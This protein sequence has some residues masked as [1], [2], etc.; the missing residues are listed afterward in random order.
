[1][2]RVGEN[3]PRLPK[4]FYKEA[5]GEAGAVLLDGRPAK[6]RAGNRLAPPGPLLLN[7]V[8]EE[9]NAQGAQI[10]F[11]AMPMTR[12]AMT[13]IDL[14]DRDAAAWRAVILSHLKSDLL[15]YRAAGPAMLVERQN[16]EWDP[17]LDWARQRRG[18]ALASAAGV[19]F[20]EQPPEAIAAG[21]RALARLS[22]ARLL[23][24]KTA[25]E[26]AGSAVIALALADGAFVP[27]ALFEAS[28]VDEMF[29]RDRWGEDAEAAAH[30]TA[31]RRDFLDA[32]RF[33]GLV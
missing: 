11:D 23:G 19:S 16:A 20:I 14:G 9:W 29:Q 21:E 28:R 5:R 32:A 31:L 25:A 8:V 15:C 22:P 10:D 4:R 27:E 18:V 26:I 3:P 1:M 6:T 33:L 24:V 17:L 7:A 30:E 13:V 2:T 12:F